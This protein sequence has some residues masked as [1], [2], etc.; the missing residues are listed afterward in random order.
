VQALLSDRSV[1]SDPS[2][3]VHVEFLVMES[4]EA[5]VELDLVDCDREDTEESDDG[6][7]HVNTADRHGMTALMYAAK[8]GNCEMAEALLAKERIDVNAVGNEQAWTALMVASFH[9]QA[10]LVRALLA[11][12]GINVNAENEHGWSALMWAAFH[13]DQESL[14]AFKA[15]KGVDMIGIERAKEE[16]T[17][18]KMGAYEVR[19]KRL[20]GLISTTATPAKGIKTGKRKRKGK[21]KVKAGAKG[22]QVAGKKQPATKGTR[23]YKSGTDSH[24]VAAAKAVA[25]AKVAA[26]KAA[27]TKAAPAMPAAAPPTLAAAGQAQRRLQ[28]GRIRL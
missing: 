13:G 1:H 28:E 9:G 23:G 14:E 6:R 5:I 16:S 12:K 11:V 21:G 27:A 22:P 24:S 10:A 7:V 20:A 3:T 8:F 26:A 19:A 2:M 4:G 15:V 17:A 25:A 18:Q